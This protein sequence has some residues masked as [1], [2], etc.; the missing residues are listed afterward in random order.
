[1]RLRSSVMGNVAGSRIWDR[2]V[3]QGPGAIFLGLGAI[4][5]VKTPVT[6]HDQSGECKLRLAG[7]NLASGSSAWQK[8]RINRGRNLSSAGISGGPC[9]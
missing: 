9:L 8:M 7:T 3:G 6:S 4:D 1:M 2:E 5:R